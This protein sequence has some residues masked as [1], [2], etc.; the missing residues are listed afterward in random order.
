MHRNLF[1]PRQSSTSRRN[2]CDRRE[3]NLVRRL[4]QA[5]DEV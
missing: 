4:E 2:D 5:L 3:R 1:Y